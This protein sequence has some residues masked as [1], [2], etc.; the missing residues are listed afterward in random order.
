MTSSKPIVRSSRW[1]RHLRRRVSGV[2]ALGLG[3]L[4]AGALYTVFVPQPQTAQA[5]GDTALIRQGEQ[6]YNNACITC[7]GDYLQGVAGRGPS[8]I[9]TGEA[10]VYFQVSTGRMPAVRQEAQ[11]KEKPV[12]FTPEEIDALGAYVQANGGG[13]TVPEVEP[14]NPARGGE[15]FRLNCTS[16]HNFTGEGGALASGKYA[17]AIV[18]VNAKQIAAAMLSGPQNMPKFSDL[19]LTPEEK[20]DIIAYILTV[21]EGSGTA[22]NPGGWGLGNIGPVSEGFIAF[23]VG[24]AA[25]VGVAVWIGA[26]A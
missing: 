5:Q 20:A 19:Q 14:G 8:L 17:P 3:L 16:C 25:L 13:P 2:L 18:D 9:G 12:Q 11:V 10:A 24:I 6:L 1:R 22:T 15:L 26:R 23:V 21:R 7:H 4:S